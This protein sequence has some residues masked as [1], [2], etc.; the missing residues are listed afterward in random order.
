V[1]DVS[2]GD[3]LR[4]VLAL[5]P[6]EDASEMLRQRQGYLEPDDV[7]VAAVADEESNAFRARVLA[8]LEMVRQEFWRLKEADLQQHLGA[9]QAV[10]LPEVVIAAQRLSQVAKER[11]ALL[12][13][14]EDRRVNPKFASTLAQILVS[15]VTTAN[16]LREREHSWMRPEQNPQHA[17][18]RH[19]IVSS[20]HAIGAHYP[21]VFALEETWLNELLAY[22]PDEE[23]EDESSNTLFGLATIAYAVVLLVVNIGIVQ[24]IFS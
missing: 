7:L 15:S 6:S 16:L 14:R 21:G 10:D 24:W 1:S 23:R 17:G 22:N 4:Q 2:P 19:A 8:R 13:L 3:Y 5:D 11:S 12:Q 9:L 18:A 20:A